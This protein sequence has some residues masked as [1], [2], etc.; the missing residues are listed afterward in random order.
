MS[1]QI[2]LHGDLEVDPAKEAEMIDYFETVYRPAARK[3]AGYVDLNLLKLTAVPVGTKPA[4][5]TYRFSI[6]Y[7]SEELRLAWVASDVHTEVWTA[8]ERFFLS[9]DYTFL[10]FDV[11]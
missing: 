9:H 10:L 7:A 1:R 11:I 6:R 5:L 8:L 3:F 4:G 2:E